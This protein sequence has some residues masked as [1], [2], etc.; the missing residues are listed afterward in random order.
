MRKTRLVVLLTSLLVAGLLAPMP[1]QAEPP[2]SGGW[3]ARVY[4]HL[5]A[6]AVLV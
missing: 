1:T 6:P 4:Y 2:G 5:L 3:F